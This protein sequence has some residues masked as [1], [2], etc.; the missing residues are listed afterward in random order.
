[1]V[2]PSPQSTAA[3]GVSRLDMADP[4]GSIG[5]S[6]QAKAHGLPCNAM[7]PLWLL[8]APFF[9]GRLGLGL[10][11]YRKRSQNSFKAPV[12]RHLWPWPS[13]R[14]FRKNVWKTWQD[15]HFHV[16]T[17]LKCGPSGGLLIL[18]CEYL[19]IL[20]WDLNLGICCGGHAVSWISHLSNIQRR[21]ETAMQ[22]C[23]PSDDSYRK[24]PEEDTF[25]YFHFTKKHQ[26]PLQAMVPVYNVDYCWSTRREVVWFVESMSCLFRM[27]V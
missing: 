1:M 27:R 24:S 20:R 13:N 11:R 6:S 7:T 3:W 2:P 23:T 16:K 18:C 21:L 5:S 26:L 4:W 17:A 15:P 10:V 25:T 8:V 14:M 22:K 12:K 9:W 19:M